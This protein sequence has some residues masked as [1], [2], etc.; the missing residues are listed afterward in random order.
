MAVMD[1]GILIK[2]MM[3]LN[4]IHD[5]RIK[6]NIEQAAVTAT[7]TKAGQP[8]EISHSFQAIEQMIN[9]PAATPGG[10]AAA[11]GQHNIPP[12]GIVQP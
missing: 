12:G 1:M 6:F 5:L 2:P 11:G 7:G 9:G 10:Q 3:L 8:F 4:G